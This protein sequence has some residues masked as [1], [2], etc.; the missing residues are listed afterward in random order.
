MR[1]SIFLAVLFLACKQVE[2]DPK[3]EKEETLTLTNVDE[4]CS[5]ASWVTTDDA[6]KYID[7]T[8][9]LQKQ[10]FFIEPA[11]SSLQL[12]DTIGFSGDIIQFTGH[13][14]TEKGV[15]DNVE[16]DITKPDSARIFRYSKYELIKRNA[17]FYLNP[18]TVVVSGKAAIVYSPDSLQMDQRMKAV[19]E[20]NFRAGAG[21]YAYSISE[22]DQYLQSVKLP[23]IYADTRKFLK[24]INQN[25]T[26]TLIKTDTLPELWGIY[27]FDPFKPPALIDE[28]MIE[29]EYRK[30]FK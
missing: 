8:D 1:Y 20:E 10:S 17:R 27:F 16:Y 29:E 22:A 26:V 14:S 12:P 30:Y 4:N 11:D 23:V 28:T 2:P 21:D 18:D 5:C 7:S 6:A 25:G 15:P 24:F 19:G 3:L 9:R 13:F